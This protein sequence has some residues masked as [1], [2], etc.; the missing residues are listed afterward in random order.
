[1]ALNNEFEAPNIIGATEMVCEMD[2]RQQSTTEV[3]NVLQSIVE[4]HKKKM[5]SAK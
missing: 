3:L 5:A 4:F 1:M 2:V